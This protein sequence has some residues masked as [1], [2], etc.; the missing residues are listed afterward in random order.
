MRIGSRKQ[1]HGKTLEGGRFREVKKF[2]ND[3]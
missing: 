3:S 1:P 2:I